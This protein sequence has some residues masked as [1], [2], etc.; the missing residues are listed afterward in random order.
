MSDFSDNKSELDE[1]GVWVKKP[2]V[3]NENT[4]APAEEPVVDAS[5]IEQAAASDQVIEQDLA[6][7]DIDSLAIDETEIAA[8]DETSV[9]DFTPQET[10]IDEEASVEEPSVI[11]ETPVVDEPSVEDFMESDTVTEQEESVPSSD[12]ISLDDFSLDKLHEENKPMTFTPDEIEET[13]AQPEAETQDS[14]PSFEDGEIDLDS[15][16]SDD[17][18]PKADSTP[19]GDVDLSSF[20]DDSAPADGDVDISAF[21]GGGDSPDFGNGDIDLEAFMGSEGFASD[22]QE[23]EEIE[24]ADPLDIDLDFET[25]DVELQDAEANGDVS[26]IVTASTYPDMSDTTE[27]EDFDA[28]FDEIVDETPQEQKEPSPAPA[29]KQEISDGSEEIDLSDF[30]FEDNPENQN[31]ILG[32][33]K[34]ETKIKAGPVDYEM[35]VDDEDP[36]ESSGSTKAETVE[37]TDTEDDEDDIQIDISQDSEKAIQKEQ[38]TDLSSPDDSFDID[39]ILNNVEDENGGT[40]SFDGTPKQNEEVTD[41]QPMFQEQETEE[42]VSGQAAES[43]E[44]SFD[45][46]EISLD[47]FMGDEGFTDGGP[48]VTGP[49]NEDGTLIIREEKKPEDDV[50]ESAPVMDETFAAE[51]SVEETVIEEPVI[52]EPVVEEPVVE[53]PVMDETFAAEPSVEE[54]VIEEPVITE[55]ILEEP[56][57]EDTV[58]DEPVIDDTFAVDPSV[59]EMVIEEPVIEETAVEEP[60]IEETVIDEPVIEENAFEEPVVTE[61]YTADTLASEE[62]EIDVPV[63]EDFAVEE[64]VVEETAGETETVIEENVEEEPGEGF[65]ESEMSDIMEEPELNTMEEENITE[66]DYSNISAFAD[67]KPEYDMT[68][69]TL[70]LDDFENIKEYPDTAAE[71]ETASPEGETVAAEETVPQASVSS[72]EPETYSVFIKTE[73][74]AGKAEVTAVPEPEENNI[75]TEESAVQETADSAEEKMD[76]FDSSSVLSKISEELASLRSEISDLKSEFAEIKKNGVAQESEETE[77]PFDTSDTSGEDSVELPEPEDDTGFFNETDED[78]TI[79][80]SGDEL[81]N[82]LSNAEFTSQTGENLDDGL[83]MD[84]DGDNLEEPVFEDSVAEESDDSEE[85]ISVPSV[86]D[87][88]VESSSTDLM[89]N[90][91]TTAEDAETISDDDILTEEDIPSPTLESLDLPEYG[92]EQEELT[93]DNIEYLKSDNTPEEDESLETGISEQPVEGVFTNWDAASEPSEEPVIEEPVIEEPIVDEI[94]SPVEASDVPSDSNEIPAGMKE[95]IKSVLS[96]MDQL[97]ENLP[98]DKIAEFAQSEQFETYKKLFSELGL[99]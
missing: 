49:Y 64:P 82:I 44:S 91:I 69:V 97:L 31:P 40:I 21:M 93:E 63:V 42:P 43:V 77:S 80:L 37:K 72:A 45:S 94:E 73:S 90:T 66:P 16:M 7:F 62:P 18:A 67:K 22:K 39:S 59:E 10:V 30:G 65:N 89:D 11:E 33:S 25:T 17:S 48:G 86:D 53:E 58:A 54:M 51:P 55:E 41:S 56:V 71:T 9:S 28:L 52:E 1:Y 29:P 78:D 87:V 46:E 61:E 70:T 24:D 13:K 8:D 98:E 36:S 96:Y 23:Q 26:G 2:P 3:E 27:V 95:E 38:E 79:A 99:S 19:D 85:E 83:K 12:E 34:E 20:M 74:S 32:D 50:N 57:F 5:F 4:D 47:D 81:S 88:L 75:T 14:I 84:F 92:D 76:A 68:G 60:V 6:E 35:N 15:F